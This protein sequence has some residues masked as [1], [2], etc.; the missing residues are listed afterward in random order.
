MSAVEWFA[1]A[2][3]EMVIWGSIPYKEEAIDAIE[4]IHRGTDFARDA[5]C[6]CTSRDKGRCACLAL[7]ALYEAECT[8]SSVIATM[9]DPGM[10]PV[11]RDAV[12]NDGPACEASR[13]VWDAVLYV[14]GYRLAEAEDIYLRCM[15]RARETG[16][17]IDSEW[18]EGACECLDDVRFDAHVLQ[19]CAGVEIDDRALSIV[20][21]WCRS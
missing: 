10:Y 5:M 20:D 12:W 2:V 4:A 8:V 13:F 19:S 1:S 15:A 3:N 16:S 9:G 18:A 11:Y 14:A 6:A 17:D 7:R 21:G